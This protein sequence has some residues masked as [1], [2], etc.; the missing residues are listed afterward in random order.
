MS[1]PTKPAVR[2]V[3][4]Y[5]LEWEYRVVGADEGAVRAAIAEV[6]GARVHTV[7]SGLVSGQGRWTSV[8]VEL[9]VESEAERDALHHALVAHASVR[10][11]M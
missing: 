1:D 7:M 10:L 8:R 4:T 5:P 2:P 6:L 3:L 11:V 9:V